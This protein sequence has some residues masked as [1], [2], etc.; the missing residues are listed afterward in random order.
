MRKLG[1]RGRLW[2]RGFHIFFI[3]AWIGVG[4][5]T[6]I[7]P[8][9]TGNAS[10]GSEL[11]AYYASVNVLDDFVIVPCAIG[12]LITG[13]LLAWQT[14]WGFF[15]HGWVIYSG[16]ATIV[17]ILLGII[18]LGPGIDTLV[19]ISKLEGLSALQNPEYV[20]AR[21]IGAILSIVWLL[22]LISAAFVSVLKPWTKRKEAEA[23]T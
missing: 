6:T 14:A 9:F 5:S 22:L 23:A 2:L 4:I 11:Y 20:S 7:I 12:T 10:N 21:N 1:R 17:A 13:L 8:F 3:G 15:K 19:A 16:T 18:W